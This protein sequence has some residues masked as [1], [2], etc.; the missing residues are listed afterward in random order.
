MP[1]QASDD[2]TTLLH[3]L[4]DGDRAAPER[5]LSL[6]YDELRQM[7]AGFLGREPPQSWQTTDLAHEALVRLLGPDILTRALS[8]PHFFALAARTMRQLLVDHARSRNARKRGGQCQRVP[9]DDVVD[10]FERQ[11]LD[12]EAVRDALDRLAGLHERQS[13]VVTLRFFGGFTVTEVAAQLDVSV[14]TV[15]SDFRIA[16]AWLHAQLA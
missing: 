4:R 13:Q 2:L 12:I 6:V 7:A 3:G 1:P 9:L 15:E 11:H 10:Y 14:S 5:L 8:R 16:R